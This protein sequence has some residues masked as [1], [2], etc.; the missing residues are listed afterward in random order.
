MIR[1]FLDTLYRASGLASSLL[2]VALLFMV[3]TQMAA[4]W[5]EI[6]VTGLTEIAGYCMAASSFFGLGYAFSQ[7][8]HIRVNLIV[9][10]SVSKQQ[11]PEILCTSVATVIA[12]AL[13]YFAIRTTVISF[14]LHQVSQGQ[15]AAQ[16][17]IPQTA[18]SIGSTIFLIA[19]FD[20]LMGII[21]GTEG[22]NDADTV[23]PRR[24][25]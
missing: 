17:W 7:N 25:R 5:L 10:R 13:A 9:G 22:A 8:A 18:M 24:L 15:D 4:R 16:I 6:P 2:L 23:T 12:A 14:Q 20:R 11:L 1:R 21:G 3:I 19:L